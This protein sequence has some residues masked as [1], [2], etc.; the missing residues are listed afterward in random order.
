[1]TPSTGAATAQEPQELAVGQVCR[2]RVDVPTIESCG[3]SGFG[4]L[5]F[6]CAKAGCPTTTAITL[7][8]I[9]DDMVTVESE[10]GTPGHVVAT[11][12][13]RLRP[14]GTVTIIPRVSGDLIFDIDV[15]TKEG[16][17]VQ[18]RVISVI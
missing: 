18:L 5:R 14:G 3:Y 7:E 8:N 17:T 1:M 11:S 15:E 6:N 9:G 4:D 13:P 12:Y 16:Q 2:V 10:S